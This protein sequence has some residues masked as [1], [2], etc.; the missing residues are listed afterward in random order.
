MSERAIANNWALPLAKVYRW[1]F[2]EERKMA[3][4]YR[5]VN[6]I[7]YT[8]KHQST[9]RFSHAISNLATFPGKEPWALWHIGLANT[10]RTTVAQNNISNLQSFAGSTLCPLRL[11][12][13]SGSSRDQDLGKAELPATTASRTNRI[14]G[15]M[16]RQSPLWLWDRARTR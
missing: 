7:D 4:V 2:M 8:S 3:N 12:R 11:G 16:E 5:D 9:S 14:G 1:V 13:E 15:G 10:F 6:C